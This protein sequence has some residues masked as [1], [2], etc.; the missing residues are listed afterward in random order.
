VRPLWSIKG[1]ARSA[2]LEPIG[3]FQLD[4]KEGITFRSYKFPGTNL[5]VS[6]GVDYEFEYSQKPDPAPFRIDLAITVSDREK[7][8]IFESIDSSEAS[9]LYSQEW[10]LRVTKN[11]TFDNRTYMFTLSC[12]DETK[13]HSKASKAGKF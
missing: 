9:T 11:I 3:T 6:V 10:N 1:G 4:G 2:S 12:W 5:V 13:P 7:K 8:D